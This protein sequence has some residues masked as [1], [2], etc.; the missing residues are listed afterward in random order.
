[1]LRR[2]CALAFLAFGAIFALYAVVLIR[3]LEPP[4]SYIVAAFGG[5][6][7]AMGLGAMS[8]LLWARRDLGAF[9]RA[10]RREAP[11]HGA[12]VLAAGPIRP[13]GAPLTSPLGGHPCVAYDYEVAPPDSY[14]RGT[15][16]PKRRDIVGFAMA[17][18]VVDTPLGA[19]RILGFPLLEEFPLSTERD[20]AAQARA[21]QYLAG[22]PFEAVRGLGL[23]Q[24]FAGMD[25]ALS[26][27]DGIVRKDFRLT[28][29][30][31]P[32]E[33]RALRERIVKVGEPVCALGRYDAEKRGLV[34]AGTTLNRLWPGTAG[35]VRRKV[36]GAARSSSAFGLVVFVL[37]HGVLGGGLYLSETRHHREPESEQARVLRYAVDLGDIATLERTV[38][39]GA[40]PNAR[41]AS[42]DTVLLD[43]REPEMAAAL[44]RLGADVN[45]RHHGDGDTP[46][47]RAARMGIVP[48]VKVLLAAGA[49]PQAAMTNGATALSEAERGGH[50]EVIELLR[51]GAES[52]PV[53]RP[54]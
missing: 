41:D 46:L 49:N 3:I 47:I 30:E 14:T 22:T 25:D 43:V 18:A 26:D 15:K 6:F 10:E 34:P 29:G 2:G 8:N 19:I 27:A 36:A 16:D 42:G 31:I 32:F 50:A 12:L 20:P 24:L 52:A 39:R 53:E 54:R 45:V 11:R 1:M 28:Q 38:R 51:G 35:E 4:E 17:A 21:R 7:G 13:Q 37:S 9:R 44:I 5:L 40:N 23:G 48:L 33:T